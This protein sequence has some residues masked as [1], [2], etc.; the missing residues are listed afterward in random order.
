MNALEITWM[1][2]AS[3]TSEAMN[4]F[5]KIQIRNSC[6]QKLQWIRDCIGNDDFELPIFQIYL[7]PL[8]FFTALQTPTGLFG[9]D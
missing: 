8:N 5:L 9:L 4:A 3:V 6:N 2:S 7:F 1:K